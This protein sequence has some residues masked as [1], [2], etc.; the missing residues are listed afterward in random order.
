MNVPARIA[1]ICFTGVASL[2]AGEAG[3]SK[4]RGA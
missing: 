1:V 4:W 2:L 3:R